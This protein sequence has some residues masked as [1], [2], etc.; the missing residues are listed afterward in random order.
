MTTTTLDEIS[1]RWLLEHGYPKHY[2]IDCLLQSATCLRELN[3]D[4]LKI[5]NTRN[6]PLDNTASCELP[7]DFVEDVLVGIP[8]GQ[9]I[10]NLPKQEWITS[11][12]LHDATTGQ[13]VPYQGN[14]NFN[15]NVDLANFPLVGWT[16]FWNVNDYGEP[17]GKFYGQHGG[18]VSGYKIL[19]QQRRIQFSEDFINSNFILMYIGDGTSIDNATQIDPQAFMTIDAFISWKKSPNRENKDSPEGRN[20]YN[21][22]RLLVA[23]LSDLDIDT[24]KNIIRQNF[25]AS[26]KN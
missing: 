26:I 2:Y 23:R 20:F 24:L 3:F 21:Q 18:I 25:H 12:R 8:F 6:L 16:F 15:I 5:V 11:L 19:K 14:S 10:I 17:T 9:G 1:N 7:D 22:R 13:F 4:T